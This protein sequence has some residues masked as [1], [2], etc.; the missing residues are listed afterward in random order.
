MSYLTYEEYKNLGF[1]EIDQTEF[2]RLLPKASDVV[3]SV[4][5]HFYKFNNIADDVPFR[6]EQFKKA[7]ACQVEYFYETGATTSYGVSEPTTVTIGRTS[8]SS[9]IRGSQGSQAPKTSI[10]AS[11][12]YM[13]LAPTGLL[14]K[15]IGVI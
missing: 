9:G 4:T 5:R 15:G 8:M 3:D 11:E 10:V 2:D 6:Q 7:V 1:T 12:V 14:Y 13:Y